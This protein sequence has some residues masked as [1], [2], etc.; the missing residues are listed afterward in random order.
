MKIKI[1]QLIKY[2]ETVSTEKKTLIQQF[3]MNKVKLNNLLR[4]RVGET[5]NL[6]N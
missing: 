6:K 2:S 1:F 5:I 3:S 4:M